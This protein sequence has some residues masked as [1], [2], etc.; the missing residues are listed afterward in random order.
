MNIYPIKI[1]EIDI[2]P[3]KHKNGL[4]AFTSFTLN[5]SFHVNSVAIYTDL[6]NGGFRL[7]YPTKEFFAG[8]KV[9]CFYPINKETGR[10]ITE[11]ITKEFLKIINKNLKEEVADE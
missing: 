6:T 11:A 9:Y 4:V 2:T 3:V 7:S 1:S 5:E 10:V 8:K